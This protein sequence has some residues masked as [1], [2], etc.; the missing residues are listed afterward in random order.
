MM[1]SEKDT[2]TASEHNALTSSE[3]YGIIAP[4]PKTEK[5]MI[6]Y[7]CNKDTE[8]YFM[9]RKCLIMLEFLFGVFIGVIFHEQLLNAYNYLLSI[10]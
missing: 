1:C 3:G 7:K 5:A 9:Q 4:T 10:I 8:L 2:T 6:I